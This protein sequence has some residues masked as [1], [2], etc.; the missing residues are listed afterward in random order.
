MSV[1]CR[2]FCASCVALQLWLAQCDVFYADMLSETAADYVPG[3][4]SS[5]VDRDLM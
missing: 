2:P 1:S 5:Q 4:I 3:L